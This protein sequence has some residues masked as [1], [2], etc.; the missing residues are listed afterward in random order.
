LQ[1]DVPFRMEIHIA[2]RTHSG[3]Y[4]DGR[5]PFQIVIRSAELGLYKQRSQFAPIAEP[6]AATAQPVCQIES[7]S[8]RMSKGTPVL[9]AR[10]PAG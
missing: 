1:A 5:T 4:C 10:P 8:G 2:E 9:S 3:K 6:V 7:S